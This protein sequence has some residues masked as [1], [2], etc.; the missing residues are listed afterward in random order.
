MAG[1]VVDAIIH[2]YGYNCYCGIRLKLCDAATIVNHRQVRHKLMEIS[3]LEFIG[4]FIAASFVLALDHVVKARRYSV[5]ALL[6]LMTIV[7][8]ILGVVTFIHATPVKPPS[9]LRALIIDGQ[10][11]H[12][13]K[14][15]TPLLRKALESSG[16]FTVD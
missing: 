14:T 15:T 7:C 1:W 9:K 12:D 2:G 6:I 4:A 11:N 13:W 16:R 3:P 8:L 5:R 10:N